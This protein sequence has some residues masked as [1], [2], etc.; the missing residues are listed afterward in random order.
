MPYVA[1]Y[2]REIVPYVADNLTAGQQDGSYV[3]A[4]QYSWF[5]FLLSAGLDANPLVAVDL[6]AVSAA[7]MLLAWWRCT[8]SVAKVAVVLGMLLVS[9]HVTFYNWTLFAAAAALL[10]HSDLRPRWLVPAIIVGLAAALAAIA[11]RDP[12]PDPRRPLPSARHARP[13]LDPARR[14]RDA[15]RLPRGP[16]ARRRTKNCETNSPRGSSAEPGANKIYE[17]SPPGSEA[18]ALPGGQNYETRRVALASATAHARHR[19]P[20]PHSSLAPVGAVAI[21]AGFFGLMGHLNR[22]LAHDAL[23]SRQQVGGAARRLPRAR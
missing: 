14:A 8:P 2:Y 21:A 19:A 10:L 17:A 7:A 1:S 3:H 15:L 6:I 11:E 5:G 16:P 23:F 13:L 4:W 9:P 12:V 20:G 22:P 18:G